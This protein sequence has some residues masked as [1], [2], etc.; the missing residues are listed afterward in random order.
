MKQLQPDVLN[1]L[2]AAQFDGRRL[3]LTGQLDRSL[4]AQVNKVIVVAG[5]KWDRRASAH[6][7]AGDAEEAIDQIVLTG[8]VGPKQELGQFDTPSTVV[9]RLLELARIQPGMLVLEPSAGLGNIATMASR[10]S[11]FVTCVEIDASRVAALKA[12]RMPVVIHA[13]FLWMTPADRFDRLP[14]AFSSTPAAPRRK[15]LS[16]RESC[17]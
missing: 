10:W 8:G 7:F 12:A 5:G 9:T 1:A 6:L 17:G 15:S 16:V 3:T 14:S 13:D 4:Y 11:E 2:A